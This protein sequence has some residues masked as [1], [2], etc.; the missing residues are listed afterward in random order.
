MDLASYEF[1]MLFIAGTTIALA[2]Y[3]MV[4]FFDEYRK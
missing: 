1:T 3:G 4:I 2:V